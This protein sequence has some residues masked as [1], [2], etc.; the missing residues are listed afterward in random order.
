M[1][2]ISP[3]ENKKIARQWLKQISEPAKKQIKLTVLISIISGVLLIAQLY[4]LSS[5]AYDAYILKL[6]LTTL[7]NS[8]VIIFAIVVIRAGLS[9]LKEVVSYKSA[10]IVKKQLRED[11]VTHIDKLGPVKSSQTANANL[12]TSAMEQ[13]DGVTNYLTKFLPQVTLSA[14]MPMIILAFVLYQ[15]I[16][17]GIILLICMPLIPLFM[18]I[19]GLSAESESQKHFKELARMSLTFLDTLKGLTTLKLFNKS[20]I[21]SDKIFE[22]SDSYRVRT[23]KVLKLAFLSSAVLELFSAASIALVA[24]YLGMGFINQGSDNHIWWTLGDLNLQGALFIL[25]LAPE[26]FM[27]LRELSTHYHAKADA[28]GA[29][30]EIAKIFELKPNESADK[31]FDGNIKNIKIKNLSVSYGDK[32][33]LKNISLDIKQGQKIAVIGASGAGKTTFINTLLGFIEYDGNIAIT[34]SNSKEHELKTLTE[35]SW[36]ENISWLGQNASLFKGSIKENL[37]LANPNVSENE[38]HDAITKANID[39]FIKSLPNGL[40]TQIGEQNLGISGG[41]AQRLALAR[42]YIKP[43]DLLILDEPTASL[44]KESETKV[45]E[46]LTSSWQNKTVIML[47]HKL[48]FLE[49][50]DKIIVLENGKIVQQGNFKELVS[51]Q[52]KAFYSFYKNEVVL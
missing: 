2:T 52:D 17:A 22:A 35:K 9:W 42:A 31:V 34:S 39:T 48:S 11:I 23:M 10:V 20:K 7:T 25:L 21:Q 28:V 41:Q 24:I 18:I 38:I 12:I 4:L 14:V 49:C 1:P 40:N 6:K 26:F 47:T 33:V 46:S 19:V 32:K 44:D 37:Q 3:K 43:H 51:Q 16:V 27:P 29:A 36:L 15:N 8:F 45:I 30:L 50:V 5:I 13:V